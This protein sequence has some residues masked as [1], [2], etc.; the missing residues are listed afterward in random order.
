MF[1]EDVRLE[2]VS[3]RP[4]RMR[5]LCAGGRQRCWLLWFME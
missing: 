3:L 4:W 1:T 2:T 5:R